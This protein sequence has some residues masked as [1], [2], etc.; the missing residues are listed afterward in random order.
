[1][2]PG[3]SPLAPLCEITS[4]FATDLEESAQMDS[5]E[6]VTVL[7]HHSL[8]IQDVKGHKTASKPIGRYKMAK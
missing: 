8:S 1:V 3:K 2:Q 7:D 5:L 4:G 6:D